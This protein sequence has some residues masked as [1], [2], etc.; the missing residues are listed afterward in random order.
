MAIYSTEVSTT[1]YF[2]TQYGEVKISG[3]EQCVVDATLA[4]VAVMSKNNR[5]VQGI[6]FIRGQFG[7]GLKEAKGIY[8]KVSAAYTYS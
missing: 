3:I 1:F 2:D 7:L 8:D 4:Y 6:K 5:A